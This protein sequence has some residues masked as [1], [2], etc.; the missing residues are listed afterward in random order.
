ME[1]LRIEL[2][3][4]L[5]PGKFGVTR[6]EAKANY[7]EFIQGEAQ[8]FRYCLESNGTEGIIDLISRV[9]EKMYA[10]GNLLIKQARELGLEPES[11]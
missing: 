8:K 7:L 3:P 10:D 2:K 9:V 1:V 6:W 5:F 11:S 4:G